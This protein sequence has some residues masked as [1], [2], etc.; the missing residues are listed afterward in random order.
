MSARNQEP[1]YDIQ[2]LVHVSKDTRNEKVFPAVKPCPPGEKG[3]LIVGNFESLFLSYFCYI[4][5][6][7]L[8]NDIIMFHSSR[9]LCHSKNYV[10]VIILCDLQFF[11]YSEVFLFHLCIFA[12][13][14]VSTAFTNMFNVWYDEGFSKFIAKYWSEVKKFFV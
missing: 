1:V 10:E 5:P 12:H 6:G 8:S 13:C 14:C 2:V 9:V 3:Q 11:P 4:F 7:F